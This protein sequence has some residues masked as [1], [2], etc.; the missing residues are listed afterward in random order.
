MRTIKRLKP[1]KGGVSDPCVEKERD[2]LRAVS[3][4]FFKRNPSM[5]LIFSN[6]QDPT[7]DLVIEWLIAFGLRFRRINSED[8]TDRSVPL[9]FSPGEGRVC[10]E[11]IQGMDTRYT[12][13]RVCWYRRWGRFHSPADTKGDP[14]VQQLRLEMQREAEALS[15]FLFDRFKDLPWL[16]D[17]ERANAEEKLLTLRIAERSGLKIPKSII[18]NRKEKVLNA[19]EERERVIVKPLGDPAGFVDRKEARFHRIF[20][21]SFDREELGE[22]PRTFFPSFFQERIE[23]RYE[24]RVFYLDGTLYSTALFKPS[25]GRTDIKLDHGLEAETTQMNRAV[26]PP[27]IK[28]GLR[29]LMKALG[30]N[31]GSI[32]LL[33]RPNGEHIFLEVNPIGQFLGYGEGV[34][35]SLDR[36]IAEWLYQKDQEYETRASPVL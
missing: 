23:A 20:A 2:G 12:P 8:L 32:D 11:G 7:T 27:S 24:L 28:R 13:V 14:N 21:E 30:L 33:V 1:P 9:Y 29:R 10:I 5:I 15:R 4:F 17:P 6:S 19:F 31:S 35:H 34:N 25:T 36:K 3:P 22:L 26:I 18:T 16:T